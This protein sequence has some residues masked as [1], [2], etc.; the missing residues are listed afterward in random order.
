MIVHCINCKSK[1]PVPQDEIFLEGKLLK[2]KNCHQEWIYVSKSQNLEKKIY[3]L[4]LNL[5]KTEHRLKEQRKNL[6]EKIIGLEKDLKNK[7]NE[8]SR[9]N[10]VQEK[11]SQYDKR[12][13]DIEKI[14]SEN[15]DFEII[16]SKLEKKLT[17]VESDLKNININIEKKSN[18]LDMK[19][20]SINDIK[21]NTNNLE[22]FKNIDQIDKNKNEVLDSTKKDKKRPFWRG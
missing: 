9:Q 17:T 20:N 22:E 10:A 8:L 7:T 1:F 6:E 2:C 3:S 13:T 15:S 5:S 11:I 14:N 4:D 18:Y 12:I 19:I 21:I 16:K